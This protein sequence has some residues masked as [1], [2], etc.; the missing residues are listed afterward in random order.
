MEGIVAA[1]D[2]SNGPG[3][4]PLAGSQGIPV[5]PLGRLASMAASAVFIPFLR[6][7]ALRI[8]ATGLNGSA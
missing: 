1:S 6:T 5:E 8:G 2:T 3:C 7:S 4:C